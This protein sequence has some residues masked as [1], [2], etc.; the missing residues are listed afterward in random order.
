M[1]TETIFEDRS[2]PDAT[3]A[4]APTD[5]STGGV[6]TQAR[7]RRSMRA[8]AFWSGLAV[9]PAAIGTA[10]ALI[11][12]SKRAGVVAGGISAIG[13]ATVRWQLQRL[14]SD[15]PAYE[16]ERSFGKLEIRRYPAH[17]EARTKIDETAVDRALDAGFDRLAVY[18]FGANRGG[19]ELDMTAPVVASGISGGHQVAFVMP[20]E[21]TLASLPRPEDNR[22]ELVEIPERTL[23]VLSFRGR[24]TDE[25]VAQHEAELRR[26]VTAAGLA[27]KG[28]ATLAAFDPPWTLP[29]VRRN[30]LWFEVV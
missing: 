18:I 16:V 15:E 30:E 22:V 28:H 24:S 7:T 5:R 19:E 17:V 14:W 8:A 9:A 20:P 3:P 12:R 25:N 26:Q 23:A 6:A 21:R 1:P 2:A 27:A 11:T 10:V 13:L 29:A 4:A